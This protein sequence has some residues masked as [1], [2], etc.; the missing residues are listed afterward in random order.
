MRKTEINSSS[1]QQLKNAGKFFFDE[2][3]K[4]NAEAWVFRVKD[5]ILI[6]INIKHL[7]IVDEKEKSAIVPKFIYEEHF[8]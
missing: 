6:R 7:I 3:T 8:V 4:K 5:K 2:I 1:M